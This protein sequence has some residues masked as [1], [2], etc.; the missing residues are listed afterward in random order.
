ML[1]NYLDSMKPIVDKQ[2]EEFLPKKLNDTWLEAHLGKLRYGYN[3][4]SFSKISEPMWDILKRVGKSWRPIFMMLCCDALGGGSKIVDFIPIIE[5]IHNGSLMIDD[6]EDNSNER[7]GK[8]CTHKTF[9][10]DVAINA[11]NMMYYL[12]YLLIKRSHLNNRT[13]LMIHEAI[14]EEMIKLHFGQGLD[15]HWHNNGWGITEDLYLQM[16]A[17]KTGTLARL[18]VRIGT[19]LGNANKKQIDALTKFAESIGVAFQIQD[20]ILNIT[21]KKWGKEFGE[22][23]IEG[24][25]S[26]MVIRVLEVGSNEDK[27]RLLDILNLKTGDEKSIQEAIGIIERYKAIDYAKSKAKQLVTGTWDSLEPLLKD[28]ESKTKLKLFADFAINREM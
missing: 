11:G 26:L 27:Q 12:P 24:K 18:A 28:S 23:I 15:I 6:I 7:R 19:L 14:A 5:L 3:Q 2:L 20:D 22:D 21:N 13:K 4:A 1:K 8:P 17:F 16:C 10:I 25:R 9:G